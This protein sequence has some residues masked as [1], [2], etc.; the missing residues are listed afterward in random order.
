[1]RLSASI[2][3]TNR[4]DP[5]DQNNLDVLFDMLANK[6][7]LS[8]LLN[9]SK[10][11]KL[12]HKLGHVHPLNFLETAKAH[13]NLKKNVKQLAS[14][15]DLVWKTFKNHFVGQMCDMNQQGKIAPY[16]D[17]FASKVALNKSLVRDYVDRND[18]VDLLYYTIRN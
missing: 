14:N 11:E 7:Y 6:S 3:Y 4:L 9:R 1:M 15:N 18:M 2:Q 10:L 16:V 13:P 17:D 8:L 12:H 5:I